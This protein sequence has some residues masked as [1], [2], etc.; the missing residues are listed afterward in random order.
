VQFERENIPRRQ[1]NKPPATGSAGVPFQAFPGP[2][3][4]TPR[5]VRPWHTTRNGEMAIISQ[6]ARILNKRC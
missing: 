6:I 3:S 4:L 1:S 5:G 2:Y